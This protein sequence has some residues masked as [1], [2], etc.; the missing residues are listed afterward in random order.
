MFGEEY[1]LVAV[2]DYVLSKTLHHSFK[3]IIVKSLRDVQI[4]TNKNISLRLLRS[5]CSD[6]DEEV[7]AKIGGEAMVEL[8]ILNCSME[9]IH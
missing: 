9:E 6:K 5:Q 7:G 2:A 4:H 8:S 1:T 3:F